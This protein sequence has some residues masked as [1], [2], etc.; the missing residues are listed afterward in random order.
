MT[1][2]M[3]RPYPPP[4]APRRGQANLAALDPEEA[5]EFVVDAWPCRSSS[6]RAYDL[7][8]PLGR[9]SASSAYTALRSRVADRR[10]LTVL[11]QVF[12]D[13]SPRERGCRS[14]AGEV[15]STEGRRGARSRRGHR[16]RVLRGCG[17]RVRAGGQFPVGWALRLPVVVGTRRVGLMRKEPI[18]RAWGQ[19]WRA[20]RPA[21]T[22][23]SSRWARWRHCCGTS[24]TSRRGG[25][26]GEVYPGRR[27]PP[28]TRHSGHLRQAGLR[29]PGAAGAKRP[30][31]SAVSLQDAGDPG[32]RASV[33]RRWFS[34]VRRPGDA[35]LSR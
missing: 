33:S 31:R 30:P 15:D 16:L 7:P 6:P 5:R 29:P 24:P 10:C 28:A 2:K 11:C 1:A 9:L 21:A 22:T 12:L 19:R 14:A 18:T 20:S 3:T 8:T 13:G 17:R 32:E 4:P 35:L 34:E 23:R 25:L 26:L 27:R